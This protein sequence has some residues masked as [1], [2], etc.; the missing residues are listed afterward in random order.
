M[1]VKVLRLGHRFARDKRLSTHVGLTARAFGASELFLDGKDSRIRESIERVAS[2]W[3]G[4]FKVSFVRDWLNVVRDFSGDRIHLTMYGIGVKEAVD[5][6]SVKTDKL[7][8]IGGGKVPSDL[9]KI[10]DYNVSIGT[11]PHSEVAALAVFLDRLFD[12]KELEKDFEGKK[13]I[14]PM[15]RGKMVVRN[16]DN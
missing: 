8:I 12:G 15:E 1:I 14:I 3:G 10:V 7:I 6:M 9:Y 2:E 13:R 4:D 16:R 11:Q 5:K